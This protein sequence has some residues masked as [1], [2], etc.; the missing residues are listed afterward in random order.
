MHRESWLP[1]GALARVVVTA[2]GEP[3][4]VVKEGKKCLELI[5]C[6][7]NEKSDY[8]YALSTIGACNRLEKILNAKE[9][10]NYRKG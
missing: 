5:S 1:L 9:H 10:R 2:N 7:A 8:M 6:A 4:G 3:D